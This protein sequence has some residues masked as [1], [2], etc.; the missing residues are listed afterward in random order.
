[1]ADITPPLAAPVP[2]N[3]AHEVTGFDCGKISLN[4]W[5]HVHAAKSEG[6]GARTYV[7]CQGR[8]VA[9]Y[10][11]LSAGAV[12]RARAPSNISRNM[13]D[14]VPVLLLGRL[15]VDR[16][17]HGKGIGA[18]LLQDALKRALNASRE[19]GAR[20]VLVHAIDDEAASFYRQ[21]RFKPFP[22]DHRILYLPMAHIIAVL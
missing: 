6:K 17:F 9:G 15:A 4:D 5:L 21:Y 14:P 8:R 13:P 7:A 16:A 11:A 2:L 12:E 22:A 3:P 20:A 10:Y 1:M 19:I 18:G